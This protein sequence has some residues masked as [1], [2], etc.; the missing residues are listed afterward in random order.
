MTL[1][2]VAVDQFAVGVAVK[3]D[4][5][6][7]GDLVFYANTSTTGIS[8]VGIY[9]GGGRWVSALDEKIGVK[10]IALDEPYWKQRYAG[11]RRIT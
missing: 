4:A 8:H 2:R 1:P 10:A 3:P 11:A 5:L 7:P 9:I 6:R